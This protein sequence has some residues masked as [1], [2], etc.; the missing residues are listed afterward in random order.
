MG[1]NIGS[2][3]RFV[4]PLLRRVS[5]PVLSN[6]L[7]SVQPMPVMYINY[8]MNEP[9][10]YFKLKVK[11]IRVRCRV[12][13]SLLPRHDYTNPNI[14]VMV[15]ASAGAWY[16]NVNISR[17]CVKSIG[18]IFPHNR[19]VLFRD[20]NRMLVSG[21]RDILGKFGRGDNSRFDGLL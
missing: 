7:I 19:K 2:F 13:V 4:F 3:N 1:S 21:C 6:K 16:W 18:K 14:D 10:G 11:G 5:Y 17:G 8:E 12:A 9:I 15:E 20:E